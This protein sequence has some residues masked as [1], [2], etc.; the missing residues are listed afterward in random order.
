MNK[1]AESIE[2]GLLAN[3][4]ATKNGKI[5]LYGTIRILDKA[6]CSEPDEDAGLEC[7]SHRFLAFKKG[8]HRTRICGEHVE[9]INKKR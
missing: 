2:K 8:N 1:K 5:S 4:Y 7:W 9:I 6:V 3:S